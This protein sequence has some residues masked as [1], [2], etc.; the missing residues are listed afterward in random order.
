MKSS[1]TV[2]VAL[3]SGLF[4][5]VA[6]ASSPVPRP[7]SISTDAHI[8]IDADTG[9]VL[10]EH[11]ADKHLGPAS[12]TKIMTAYV[13]YSA[14]ED[15]RIRFDDQVTVSEDAW[16]MGGSRMFLEVGTEVNVDDLLDGMVIQS[17]ND[18]SLS[19]AE[20]TAGSEDAF[21]ELMNTYAERLGLQNSHFANSHGMPHPEQYTSARD[22][23]KL[24]RALIR[25]FPE[26]YERYS[27]REFSYNGIT[28][29]NRNQLLWSD[30]SVDGVKTGYTSESGYALVSSA[31]RDGMRLISVVMGSNSVQQ[32]TTDSRSMLNWGFRFFATD[33]IYAVGDTIDETRLW[34]GVQDTLALGPSEALVVTVPQGDYDDLVATL[35]LDGPAVAPVEAGETLGRVT[36]THGDEEIATVPVVALEDVERAGLFGRLIDRA[37]HWFEEL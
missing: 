30:D 2:V 20:H 10:A 1:L 23:A 3:L 31:E 8:L 33:T 13:V 9:R 5:A 18:A 16:R 19:L 37:R 12:L 17:G 26:H 29:H 11:N 36:I 25:E 15:D 34:E 6:V 32:R 35:H 7:P 28:Q 24:A 27:Q 22:M 4:A 14:L 21:V